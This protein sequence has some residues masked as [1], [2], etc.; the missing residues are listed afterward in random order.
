MVR[1]R[2]NIKEGDT[3]SEK[4]E[5]IVGFIWDIVTSISCVVAIIHFHETGRRI[6]LASLLGVIILLTIVDIRHYLKYKKTQ[7]GEEK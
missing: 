4:F 2:C 7:G 6:L 3:M 1:K 5:I